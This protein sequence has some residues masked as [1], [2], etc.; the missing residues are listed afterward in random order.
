MPKKARERYSMEGT[1]HLG[2]FGQLDLPTDDQTV[3]ETLQAAGWVVNLVESERALRFEVDG[4]R[5]PFTIETVPRPDVQQ[6][7]ASRNGSC[8]RGLVGFT[9]SI[10]STRLFDG[11]H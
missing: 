3:C 9:A 6:A 11:E 2:C 4:Q 10:D 7:L 5:V 8:P 1:H